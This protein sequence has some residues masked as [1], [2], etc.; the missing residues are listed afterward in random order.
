MHT[1]RDIQTRAMMTLASK[2]RWFFNSSSDDRVDCR[3]AD[4]I[5]SNIAPR[6]H[7]SP[8]TNC[9]VFP[10]LSTF[11]VPFGY[12]CRF[13]VFP[14]SMPFFSV[15][16]HFFRFFPLYILQTTVP[17]RFR[18]I[19]R[20]DIHQPDPIC[21]MQCRWAS[22]HVLAADVQ[23]V[24]CEHWSSFARTGSVGLPS[25][26]IIWNQ[27]NKT[28]FIGKVCCNGCD[29]LL[30]DLQGTCKIRSAPF[31]LCSHFYDW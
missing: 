10:F 8:S 11:P 28:N 13:P 18:A 22:V 1:P 15:S 20:H 4:S 14:L 2:C 9:A 3:V 31:C 12:L 26:Q 6:Y 25:Y 19:S 7:S 16:L 5:S 30:A 27:E 24:F 23:R 29:A 21:I 17:T